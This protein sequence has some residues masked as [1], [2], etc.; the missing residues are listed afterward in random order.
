MQFLGKKASCKQI[1]AGLFEICSTEQR[2]RRKARGRGH[3][4]CVTKHLWGGQLKGR[5]VS[6][7]TYR[8][9]LQKERKLLPVSSLEHSISEP[10]RAD[11]KPQLRG[12]AASQDVCSHGL[13]D[14]GLCYKVK[15][16]VGVG[17]LENSS[18]F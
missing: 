1:I 2:Q 10:G 12:A 8:G 17:V 15:I 18:I 16:T 6:L 5:K 14:S 4:H 3:T 9:Q 7:V 11:L 13:Q